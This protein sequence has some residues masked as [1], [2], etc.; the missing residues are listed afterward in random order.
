M[1]KSSLASQSK[2]KK[3]MLDTSLNNPTLVLTQLPTTVN[4]TDGCV[5]QASEVS[6]SRP[7]SQ[8]S[9]WSH[10]RSTSEG[11]DSVLDLWPPG[12]FD[13]N[14]IPTSLQAA[15]TV[16]KMQS[17]LSSTGAFMRNYL[18]HSLSP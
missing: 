17:S 16:K 13:D 4:N 11:L 5:T 1:D 12:A 2:S 3:A 8:A 14:K 9:A 15:R 18:S 10:T 6:L 7:S